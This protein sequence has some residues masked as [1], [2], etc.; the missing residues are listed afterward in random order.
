M[1]SGIS[2]LAVAILLTGC[3]QATDHSPVVPNAI[4]AAAYRSQVDA[5]ARSYG[6][7][8]LLVSVASESVDPQGRASKWA[9]EYAD[10]AQPRKAYWFHVDSTGIGLDRISPMPVGAALISGKWFDSDSALAFA[11]QAGGEL[12][13]ERNPGCHITASVG[14]PVVPDPAT[15]WWIRYV[16]VDGAVATLLLGIDAATGAVNLVYP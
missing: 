7:G 16:S 5:L 15:T 12:F 4:T 13:R 9:F 1:K 6:R 8:L 10:T 11:E 3:N 2:F 14:E